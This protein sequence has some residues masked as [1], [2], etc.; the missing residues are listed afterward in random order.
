MTQHLKTW[1]HLFKLPVGEDGAVPSIPI[2]RNGKVM[3]EELAM[4]HKTGQMQL[5]VLV[6]Y[7]VWEET[8]DTMR[9]ED[10]K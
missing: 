8:S 5:Y 2:P 4:D 6:R 7:S 1:W 9:L 3:R 10:V